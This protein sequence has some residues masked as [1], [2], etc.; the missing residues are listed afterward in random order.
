M[1]TPTEAAARLQA[2]ANAALD[3]FDQAGANCFLAALHKIAEYLD[4]STGPL[5]H[6]LLIEYVRFTDEATEIIEAGE[7]RLIAEN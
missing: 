1:P 7:L 5:D 3:G 4:T 2:R 6:D